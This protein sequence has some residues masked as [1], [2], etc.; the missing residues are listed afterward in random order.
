MR[1]F[2]SICITSISALALSLAPSVASSAPKDIWDT[3]ATNSGIEKKVIQSICITESGIRFDDGFRRPWPYVLNSRYGPMFFHT[4]EKASEMLTHLISLKVK[5]IDVGMCQIN[6]EYHGHRVT[7]PHDLLDPVVN[8]NV[9]SRYLKELMTRY[10]GDITNVVAAY[11]TGS[12][13]KKEQ[14]DR[15]QNYVNSVIKVKGKLSQ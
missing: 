5:N 10:N 1:S 4:K 7:N 8:L 3:A 2:F 11:H 13:G 6:L 14:V 9:T 15:G 12:L